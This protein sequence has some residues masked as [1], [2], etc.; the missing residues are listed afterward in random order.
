MMNQPISLQPLLQK[1]WS[2][3]AFDSRSVEPEKLKLML[4]ALRWAPSCFNEQPWHIIIA[5]K[6]KLEV[7]DRLLSCLVE[8]NQLWAKN[9]PVLMLSVAKLNFSHNGKENRH[10]WH[11]V[12]LAMENLTIQGMALDIYVHQMAGFDP[13]A[14][15]DL[16][17]IPPDFAP[18]AMSA[19]GYLGDPP[20]LPDNLRER[21]LAIRTRKPLESFVFTGNWGQV[22]DLAIG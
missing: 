7:Y 18:V 4:E 5:T 19:I 16:F 11:D 9:A 8:A 22:S 3:R 6:E 2:P 17:Q 21:E 13:Q 20:I 1:R 12:G 10:A 15:R 14:A